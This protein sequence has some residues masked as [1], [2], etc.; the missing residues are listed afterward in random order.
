MRSLSLL[1]LAVVGLIVAP[2]TFGSSAMAASIHAKPAH[3]GPPQRHRVASFCRPQHVN[4]EQLV[5]GAL[6]APWFVGNPPPLYINGAR[7]CVD[8]HGTPWWH[9]DPA[10]G[11]P[12]IDHW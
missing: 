3:A 2:P 8:P 9:T 10:T 12:V 5:A 11:Y 1:T 4:R 6:S 7:V